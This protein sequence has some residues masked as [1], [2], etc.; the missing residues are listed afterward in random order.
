MNVS[1]DKLF[2]LIKSL[3]KNE[4]RYFKRFAQIHGTSGNTAYL[5]LFDLIEAQK[6]FDEE[7]IKQKL[8]GTK[9][10]ENL[11]VT[12][13]YL[14][15]LILKSLFLYGANNDSYDELA[16]QFIYGKILYKKGLYSH[17]KNYLNKARQRSVLTERYLLAGDIEL[18]LRLIS[19][20]SPEYFTNDKIDKTFK[21]LNHQLEMQKAVL[22]QIKLNDLLFVKMRHTQQARTI[23]D[24]N[25]ITKTIK[26]YLKLPPKEYC[27]NSIL[28]MHHQ[29]LSLYYY[30]IGNY[31][32]QYEEMRNAYL[33]SKSS[34]VPGNVYKNILINY[35]GACHAAGKL[36]EC[37]KLIHE[38]ELANIANVSSEDFRLSVMFW[39]KLYVFID[40]CKLD[41]AV[42]YVKK[43]E[44]KIMKMD[45]GSYYYNLQGGAYAAA[46]LYF[47]KGNYSET[48]KWLN[49]FFFFKKNEYGVRAETYFKASLLYI[50]VHYELHNEELLKYFI[51]QTYRWLLKINLMNEFER[52]ILNFIRKE[53]SAPKTIQK[54]RPAFLRLKNK[55][56][57][58]KKDPLN[59]PM[60]DFLDLISWIESK[61]HRMPMENIVIGKQKALSESL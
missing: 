35:F 43:V 31:K 10:A 22:K 6:K 32:K 11:A 54:M 52:T 53:M 3:T 18:W 38:Y 41:E 4:K 15:K 61:I 50:L 55:L 60:F 57:I 30:F 56:I 27:S 29:S 59:K 49:K 21:S 40:T 8:S 45:M 36:E 20:W 51:K 42:A 25:D 14:Y 33:I 37:E 46:Y 17:A 34:E 12:K 24:I 19:A 48:L 47:V 5:T 26:P 7:K 13:I 2:V 28:R 1:S 9:L 16:Q 58:L 39:L 44:K 23:D